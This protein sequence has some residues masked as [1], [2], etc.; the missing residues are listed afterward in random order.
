MV[1]EPPIAATQKKPARNLPSRGMPDAAQRLG[2]V[3][4]GAAGH[5]A[6]RAHAPVFHGQRDFGELEA[7][8]EEAGEHHPERGAGPAERDG[9]RDAADAA[10]AHGAGHRR[11]QRLERRRLAGMSRCSSSRRG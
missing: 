7:H 11:A 10:E 2:H 4:H 9:H 8:A 1:S 6:V 3:V 5:G